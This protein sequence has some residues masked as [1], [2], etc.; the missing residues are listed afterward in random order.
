MEYDH[1]LFVCLDLPEY[2]SHVIYFVLNFREQR[3]YKPLVNYSL[4]GPFFGFYILLDQIPGVPQGS[5]PATGPISVK[6]EY[7][8]H[9]Q[10][11]HNQTLPFDP[12]YKRYTKV[13]F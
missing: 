12:M 3:N 9:S 1:L 13:E 10:R 8:S 6:F 5:I 7:D 11:Y 4:P 2:W